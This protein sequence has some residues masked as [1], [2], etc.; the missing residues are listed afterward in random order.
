MIWG[1]VILFVDYL[2]TFGSLP[3]AMRASFLSLPGDT[4][5][6]KWPQDNHVVEL[7]SGVLGLGLALP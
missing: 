3:L 6:K 4:F 2:S 5:I 1:F 7:E